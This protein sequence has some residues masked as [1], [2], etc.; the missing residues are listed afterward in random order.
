MPYDTGSLSFKMQLYRQ[1]LVNYYDAVDLLMAAVKIKN[2]GRCPSRGTD[3]EKDKRFDRRLKMAVTKM[4]ICLTGICHIFYLQGHLRNGVQVQQLMYDMCEAVYGGQEEICQ[5]ISNLIVHYKTSYDIKLAE[6]VEFEKVYLHVA[7][8]NGMTGVSDEFI[9]VRKGVSF[10]NDNVLD[11]SIQ[12]LRK[13][14]E[15]DLVELAKWMLN[16]RIENEKKLKNANDDLD[17]RRKS[18]RQTVGMSVNGEL[19]SH[20]S[21]RC[22][23]ISLSPLKVPA[24]F[25]KSINL[26]DIRDSFDISEAPNTLDRKL[27]RPE[28]F[29]N[30]EERIHKSLSKVPQQSA[31]EI[32]TEDSCKAG[33]LVNNLWNLIAANHDN[34]RSENERDE[35]SVQESTQRDNYLHRLEIRNYDHKD[36]KRKAQPTPTVDKYFRKVVR[37]ADRNLSLEIRPLEE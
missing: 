12:K 21:A 6:L 18:R 24:R 27:N 30:T 9:M 16:Y 14:T 37:K 15:S 17:S 32:T 29:S 10:G 20:S 25:N 7:I 11:P 23:T 2:A 33:G 8:K 3:A 19:K 36:F 4:L 13:S 26:N 22:S 31:S 5:F 28:N 1:S 35:V 34:N